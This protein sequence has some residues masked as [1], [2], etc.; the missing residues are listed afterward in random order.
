MKFIVQ[1]YRD[2]LWCIVLKTEY[3]S[4]I[5]DRL[6]LKTFLDITDDEYFKL[7]PISNLNDDSEYCWCLREEYAE[8]FIETILNPMAV[9]KVLIKE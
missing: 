6:Y 5:L 2:N 9:M 4:R 8:K 7:L 1:P 3:F